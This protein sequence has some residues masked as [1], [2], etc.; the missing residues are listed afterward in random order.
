MKFIFKCQHTRYFLDD[1]DPDIPDNGD[2]PE[3]GVTDDVTENGEVN[4]GRTDEYGNLV[5]TTAERS[6]AKG[7]S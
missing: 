7:K 4:G 5:V 6:D 2:E 1:E 3:N